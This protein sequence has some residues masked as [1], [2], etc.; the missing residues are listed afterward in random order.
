MSP[1]NRGAG[2]APGTQA[3]S[4][5]LKKETFHRKPFVDHRV[6]SSYNET[7][8]LRGEF[9]LDLTPFEQWKEEL[10]RMNQKKRG[11]QFR[12]PNSFIE[13]LV[14][15][16]QFL[17]YR[18]LEGVTRK[19]AELH[20]IPEAPDY[21]TLWHRLHRLQP[22]LR[23]PDYR[24]VEVASDGTGLKTSNAGEYRIFR[25]GDPNAAQKKHLVVVITAD[26]RRKKLLGL[27][28][29]VEGKGYSEPRTAANHLRTLASQ[30]YKVGKFYGDGAY[31]TH[32]MFRTLHEVGAE[33]VIKIPV[34]ATPHIRNNRHG[35][36][37]RRRAV[38]EYRALGYRRWADQ[39]GYG[40]RWPGTEG[41]FSA[42]KRKFGENTVSRTPEGLVTEGYQRFW[43]YD[44]LREYGERGG[45]R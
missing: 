34:N 18:S 43:A 41:V 2:L 1:D 9:L 44:E 16:K 26:V 10:A 37:Y 30:G 14:V 4:P 12:F 7:L 24:D 38:R 21:T 35:S 19:F 32:E 15:W 8:V 23:M 17:D 5:D 39:K 22:P 3:A 25:Y 27:E 28:V 6:W 45:M 29:H 11:G 40:I 36:K 31:P 20:L 33:P 13:W 42:V